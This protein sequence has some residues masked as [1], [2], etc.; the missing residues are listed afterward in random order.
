MLKN[1]V[2]LITGAGQGVGQGIALAMADRGA[3][4]AVAGRTLSKLEA[5]C[6]LIE[7]RGGKAIVIACDVK[8]SVSLAN[9]VEQTVTQLGTIN[10]L[11]N[12][13]QEVP[14]GALHDVSDELF[15][16]GWQS[17]PLATMRLMKLCYPH[18]K[19]GGSIVNLASTAAKRWD[20][21]GYAAYGA[22]K[23]AIRALTKGAASEWGKDNIR[24]NVVLPIA[25]S[26]G[27]D[28]WIEN[29]PDGANAFLDTIPMK[30]IG[31]CEDDIGRFV[32][33]LCSDDS[34]Y[35]N[36][37]SIAIDGGQAFMG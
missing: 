36:G 21:S 16:A 10:I 31:N 26:P 37:Q 25:T 30:R 13:A 15:E 5:T 27:L 9:C 4:I 17:G 11:V 19:G 32:A 8:D 12:N 24:S 35:V 14:L 6:A 29:D 33:S 22:V 1:K 3:Y 28:S 18:L 23:E 20:A 34:A 7:E 2:A